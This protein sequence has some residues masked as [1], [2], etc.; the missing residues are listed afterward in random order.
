MVEE[1]QQ[2]RPLPP[3]FRAGLEDLLEALRVEAGLATA[4][5]RSYRAD[6][7]LF[8]LWASA[9]GRGIEAWDE[10]EP[11]TV[12]DYLATRRDQNMAEATVAHNL[13]AV[14]VLMRHLVR[15]G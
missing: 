11:G 6:L 15:E 2:P 3:A 5:L 10:I 9:P 7:T 4:T 13:T 1:H 12:V 14:R 8:L